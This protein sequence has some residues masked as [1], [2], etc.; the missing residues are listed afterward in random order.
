MIADTASDDSMDVI[1]TQACS[2][3][4]TV[5]VSNHKRQERE[6]MTPQ[7]VTADTSHDLGMLVQAAVPPKQQRK[8]QLP[9]QTLENSS[10][11]AAAPVSSET[12]AAS[13]S[14][15]DAI[16]HTALRSS[17]PPGTQHLSAASHSDRNHQLRSIALNA[18]HDERMQDDSHNDRNSPTPALN[19]RS[20]GRTRQNTAAASPSTAPLPSSN[21]STSPQLQTNAHYAAPSPTHYTLHHPAHR[22]PPTT[23][24]ICHSKLC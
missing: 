13:N 3:M 7:A 23:A 21:H 18:H 5:F 20:S 8:L 17:Q 4:N 1:P 2:T 10:R 19:R 24:C 9:E 6:I 15:V 16:R 11:T 14:N 12:D 22:R